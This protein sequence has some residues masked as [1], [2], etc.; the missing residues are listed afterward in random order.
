VRVD[1]YSVG[2]SERSIPSELLCLCPRL[3]VLKANDVFAKDVAERG[4]SICQRLRKL[5][6]CFRFQDSEQDLHQLLYER[7]STLIRLECLIIEY[8]IADR[9]GCSEGLMIRLDCGLGHLASLQ[10]LTNFSIVTT[11]NNRFCQ[12]GRE[13]VV[14]MV[15]N[16]RKLRRIAGRFSD[17]N[18]SVF[19]S[20]G[21]AVE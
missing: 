20:H 5:T 12:P 13:E 6:I 8:P 19:E 1:I 7:L 16:W 3:E 21:I 2:L 17:D 10:Q 18:V 9:S 11:Y 15:K 4:P 14:W